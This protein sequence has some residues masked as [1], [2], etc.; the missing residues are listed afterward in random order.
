MCNA[1][2]QFMPLHEDNSNKDATF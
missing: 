2:M 1:V